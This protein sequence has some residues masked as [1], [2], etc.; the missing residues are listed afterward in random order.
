MSYRWSFT[1]GNTTYTDAHFV[2]GKL[3]DGLYR[4]CSFGNTISRQLNMQLWNVTLDTSSPMVL[5]VTDVDTNTVYAK[6]T[7]Y[8]DTVSTSP[9]SD[10]SEVTA[11][12][13]M[14]KSEAVFMKTGEWTAASDYEIVD[15][16]CTTMGISWNTTN[17]SYF[18]N[19]PVAIDQAPSIGP[20]GTTCR[21]ILSTI[22]ALRGGN[23]YINDSNELVFAP[24]FGEITGADSIAY[25]TNTDYVIGGSVENFDK[26]DVEPIVGIEFQANG[27]DSFRAP[28]DLTDEQ[29]EAL[30]GKII[31]CNLPFMASQAAV[32]TVWN[33]YDRLGISYIPYKA[34][35]AYVVPNAELGSRIQIKDTVVYLSNRTINISPLAAS[36][37]TAETTR[38]SES[39]YPR[40]DPQVR[41]AR[42]KSEENYSAITLLP[43]QIL[44][45]VY[46]KGET[47]ERI[48][49]TVTQKADEITTE[50][51]RQVGEAVG[52]ANAYTDEVT[53]VVTSYVREFDDGV[54]TGIEIG[55]SD[56]PF[57]ARLTQ[58][59]L[60]FTGEDGQ[61]AA[62]I[63]NNELNVNHM[64]TPGVSGKWVQQIADNDH[65]QI[66][67][68]GN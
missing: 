57:K 21:Q 17:R 46:T 8:I 15:E 3:S 7:Y 45:E 63:S 49:S 62:W 55:R 28:S 35:G 51:T 2:S 6:G 50:F 37:L 39:H 67:W 48:S 16:I 43:G 41:E 58:E 24:L 33:V 42:Q 47:D 25:P 53:E 31:F 59:K 27:G 65:F 23:W 4:E 40:L 44:S 13:A 66:R 9:Y 68:I 60:S 34:S 38:Q 56:T 12:D 20:N 26:S 1:N 29:W 22:G 10:Y 36:N 52:E 54:D 61:D 18:V 64:V 5:S 14:L 30:D 19:Y 32:N 11:F